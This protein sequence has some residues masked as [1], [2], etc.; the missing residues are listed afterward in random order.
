MKESVYQRRLIDWIESIGGNVVNGTYTK[1]GEADLQ[2]GI[3]TFMCDRLLFVH[4]AIEVKTPK[5]LIRFKE[6]KYKVH[7]KLQEAKIQIINAKGGLAL[8]CS[9]KE[10]VMEYLK[11]KDIQITNLSI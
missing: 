5:N 11:S 2:A 7:E 9:N 3:P 4:V 8:V 10:E 6:G 1:N